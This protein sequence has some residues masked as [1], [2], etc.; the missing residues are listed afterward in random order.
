MAPAAHGG[1]R[2]LEV[3]AISTKITLLL[4]RQKAISAETTASKAAPE[5][6]AS[7]SVHSH[8]FGISR[9]VL[10]FPS[11]LEA[12]STFTASTGTLLTNV[13][14]AP[15]TASHLE[16]FFEWSTARL[17][18]TAE[19]LIRDNLTSQ[20]GQETPRYAFESSRAHGSIVG[21]KHTAVYQ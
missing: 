8:C 2:G 4:F 10:L 18:S 21:E 12:A 17:G 16:R 11:V 20:V 15:R 3:E 13:R 9:Q 14:N 7:I 5:I 19:R 6:T 1:P